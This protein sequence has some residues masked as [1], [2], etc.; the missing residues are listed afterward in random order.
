MRYR[1][2]LYGNKRIYSVDGYYQWIEVFYKQ[3]DEYAGCWMF[4]NT[5]SI[6]ISKKYLIQNIT[7]EANSA[8]GAVFKYFN[9]VK[10]GLGNEYLLRVEKEF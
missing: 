4:H 2:C 1:I 10:N 6:N 7:V 5:K 8:I 3:E 9:Y